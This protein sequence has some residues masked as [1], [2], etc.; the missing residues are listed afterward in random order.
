MSTTKRSLEGDFLS[1]V[2]V[3]LPEREAVG[4]ERGGE[5]HVQEVMM[6]PSEWYDASKI[7]TFSYLPK[8]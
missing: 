1:C 3:G 8:I 4:L 2:E 7:D 5:L 6:I